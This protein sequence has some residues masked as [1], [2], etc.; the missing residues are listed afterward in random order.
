M[1]GV[2]IRASALPG[3]RCEGRAR[4]LGGANS[5]GFSW[6]ELGNTSFSLFIQTACILAY[7]LLASCKKLLDFLR[8]EGRAAWMDASRRM[9]EAR[10]GM[11]LMV[12]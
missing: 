2:R 10:P 5:E 3:H 1:P 6:P 4:K 11:G 8:K 7:P 12:S 9:G